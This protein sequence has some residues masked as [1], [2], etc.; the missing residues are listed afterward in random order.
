MNVKLERYGRK[1]KIKTKGSESSA[2][3]AGQ[4][5]VRQTCASVF[6]NHEKLM[7]LL[8]WSLSVVSNSEKKARIIGAKNFMSDDD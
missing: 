4:F 1:Q 3:L 6:S 5:M 2:R 7:E 8:E